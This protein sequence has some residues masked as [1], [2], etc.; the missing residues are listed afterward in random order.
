[1]RDDTG[2]TADRGEH[3]GFPSVNEAGR[4]GEYD[5]CPRNQND[6]QGSDEELKSDHVRNLLNGAVKL[7]GKES[8]RRPGIAY[9]EHLPLMPVGLVPIEHAASVFRVDSHV[10]GT[11]DGAAVLDSGR[12]D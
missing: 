10:L 12:L 4:D 8:N 6:D 7:C 9:R 11:T 3:A 1:M 5:A 2:R